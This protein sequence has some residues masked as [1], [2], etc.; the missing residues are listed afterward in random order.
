MALTVEEINSYLRTE[1]PQ[2]AF[3]DN[4]FAAASPEECAYTRILGGKAPSKW[5]KKAEPGIQIVVRALSTATAE[6][7]ANAVYAA[8][9]GKSEFMLG[10]VRV[11]KCTAE[12]SAPGYTGK[13]ES[14]RIMYSLNFTLIT[15]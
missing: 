14:N 5:T 9:H 2:I 11:V 12:Q 13:D 6:A 3:V 15:M 7:A 4:D 10:D 8:L 1:V